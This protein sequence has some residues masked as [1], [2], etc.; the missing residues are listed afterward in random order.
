[1]KIGLY[2]GTFDPWSI[3][4]QYVLEKALDVFDE[5]HVVVAVNPSKKCKLSAEERA[6]LVVHASDPTQN[7][8]HSDTTESLKL[9][10]KKLIVSTS[11]GLMAEYAKEHGIRHLV[12]GMRSTTDFEAEFNLYF[13]NNAIDASLQTW[14]IMCPPKL[15]YCS[16]TYIK[17]VVGRTSVEHIG[18]SFAAQALMLDLPL[19]TGQAFD[20]LYCAFQKENNEIEAYRLLLDM[21]KQFTSLYL[22]KNTS[23]NSSQTTDSSVLY[24][25]PGKLQSIQFYKDFIADVACD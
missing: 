4:H 25:E 22:N 9:S 14:A 8:W 12:R 13:A 7:W 21:Q 24:Q 16:S 18:T 23:K 6:K 17:S 20:L 2:A 3:G 1:M 15:I 11:D 19:L 5:M 10:S